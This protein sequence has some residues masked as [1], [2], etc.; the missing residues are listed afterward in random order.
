MFKISFIKKNKIKAVPIT[1]I[2]ILLLLFFSYFLGDSRWCEQCSN[3][4]LLLLTLLLESW[5]ISKTRNIGTGNGMQE[6]RGT[7]SLEFRGI[8]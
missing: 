1:S 3:L 2:T 7:C 6:M 4:N 8:S 5:A